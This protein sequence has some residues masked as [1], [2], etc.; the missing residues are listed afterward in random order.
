MHDEGN[1]DAVQ[2]AQG[3]AFD[4]SEPRTWLVALA[5]VGF[6][7][8]VVASVIGVQWYYDRVREQQIFVKQ[9]EPVSENLKALHARE[10]AELH[11]YRYIDR[12]KGTVR[13]PIERAMELVVK[14]SGNAR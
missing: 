1:G 8:A 11:Q 3:P 4:T 13:L 14:E 7:V 12:A 2:E 10:D 9:L 6:L 5:L